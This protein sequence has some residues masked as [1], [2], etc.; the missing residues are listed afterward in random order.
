MVRSNKQVKAYSLIYKKE[1]RV[2]LINYEVEA[3]LDKRE[4]PIGVEYLLKWLNYNISEST[5]EPIS[6][7]NH[8]KRLIQLYE[9]NISR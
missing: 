6:Q 4:S 8:C 5:W 2:S 9:R 1:K 3:I 7:L